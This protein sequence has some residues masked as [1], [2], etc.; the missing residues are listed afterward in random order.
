MAR[1]NLHTTNLSGIFMHFLWVASLL[2]LYTLIFLHFYI[3]PFMAVL[4]RLFQGIFFMPL[5]NPWKLR[6]VTID[7]RFGHLLLS[8]TAL[9]RVILDFLFKS[10]HITLRHFQLLYYRQIHCRYITYLSYSL[11]YRYNG[12]LYLNTIPLRSIV[13]HTKFILLL[14]HSTAQQPYEG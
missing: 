14:H 8:K 1:D 12:K 2:F 3:S 4:I 13:V 10:F 6:L 11:P 9:S 5:S 7:M